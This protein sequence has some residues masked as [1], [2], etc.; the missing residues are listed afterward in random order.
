M[1]KVV[2]YNVSAEFNHEEKI[3]FFNKQHQRNTIL[4]CPESMIG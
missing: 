2:S 3:E 1:M 4:F